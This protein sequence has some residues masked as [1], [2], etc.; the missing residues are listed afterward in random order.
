MANHEQSPSPRGRG[1]TAPSTN[2]RHHQMQHIKTYLKT[3]ASTIA[4]G[5]CLARQL[6]P[7]LVIYLH[8]DLGAGKT[9]LTR[10]MIHAAG[11]VGS[12]KSPTYTLAES[13][14]VMLHN[15]KT[16]I[17]HF[18]LYRMASADEFFDAGFRDVFN[19]STICV[20]E[21]PE[22]GAAILPT[23]DLD[24]FLSVEKTGRRVELRASSDK[25]SLCLNQLNFAPDL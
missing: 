18:D 25:G 7:G 14:D 10:A 22:K 17:M 23:P 21:W 12:V 16:T 20:V 13:Y 4:L 2:N 24:V 15:Q 1:R 19:Q 6:V 5:V 8:G 11:Y 3:E 9:A